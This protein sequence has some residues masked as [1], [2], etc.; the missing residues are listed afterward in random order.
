MNDCGGR[1]RDSGGCFVVP[2]AT[3][4]RRVRE[5]PTARD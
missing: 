3:L 4:G 5:G 2:G 1:G